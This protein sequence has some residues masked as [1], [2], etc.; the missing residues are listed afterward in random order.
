M[1]EGKKRTEKITKGKI[2]MNN[3]HL[4]EEEKRKL[5]KKI[6]NKRKRNNFNT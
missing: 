4:T 5:G 2:I 6:K 1:T 3:K